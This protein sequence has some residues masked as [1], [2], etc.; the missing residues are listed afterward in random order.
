PPRPASPVWPSWLGRWLRNG[1]STSWLSTTADSPKRR[2]RRC[3]A[4]SRFQV[5]ALV[6]VTLWGGGM[7]TTPWAGPPVTHAATPEFVS[8]LGPVVERARQRFEARDAAGVLAHV[9]DQYG[10]GG[11]TKADLRQQL[12]A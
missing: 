12:L 10:S 1:L 4:T 6:A 8:E 5:I 9:S 7:R 2:Y 3:M 11:V